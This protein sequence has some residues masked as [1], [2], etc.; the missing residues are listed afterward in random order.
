MIEYKHIEDILS[1][2]EEPAVRYVSRKIWTFD[3]YADAEE[4]AEE[5]HEFHNGKRI[6]MAGGT[7]PHN[8]ISIN[9][10]TA[11]NNA[12]RHID[13]ENINVYSSDMKVFIPLTN[14][15]VYSD[16]SI[17]QGEPVMKRKDI[18]LNPL[19]LIEV[20]SDSTEAY[21]RGVKFDNYQSLPTF[22]EYVLVSQTSPLVAVFYLENPAENVWKL[23]EN[24]GLEAV[25]ELRSIGC[26]LKMTD[27]YWGIFK[28]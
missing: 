1:T 14:K 5:K 8:K 24:E 16:L 27:I 18:I 17:V 23:T 13:D 22:R 7:P 20:L 15:S 10:G 25:I 19:M 6:T 28:V 26:T 4:L 11:I 2:A 9:I 3:E 12:L 21:D